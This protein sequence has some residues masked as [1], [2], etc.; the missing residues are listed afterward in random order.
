MLVHKEWLL[1]P[2]RAI[3]HLAA[4]TAIVADMHLG[5]CE[6]RQQAGEAVPAFDP[7]EIVSLFQLLKSRHE[8]LRVVVAGDLVENRAGLDAACCFH[9]CLRNMGIE[10]TVVPGNHDPNLV[11]VGL[12]VEER[13]TIGGWRIVHGSGPLPRCRVICGHYHPALRVDGRHVPCFLIGRRHMVLPAFSLDARGANV[14]SRRRTINP[15]VSR[16]ECGTLGGTPPGV[17]T[18]AIV[19]NSLVVLS[20]RPNQSSRVAARRPEHNWFRTPLHNRIQ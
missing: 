3:V 9:V 18:I 1:T 15:R 8:I 12:P 11:A 4:R 20:S 7:D 14:M 19:G 16:R 17:Q 5:Y 13:V 10:M 2:E 6:A